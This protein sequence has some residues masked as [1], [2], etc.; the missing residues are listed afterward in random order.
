MEEPSAGA[1]VGLGDLDA[2][3]AEIEEAIDERA[4]NLGLFVHLADERLDLFLGKRADAVTKDDLVLG[5]DRQRLGMIDE[6]WTH[7]HGCYH[8][9]TGPR[10]TRTAR[11]TDIM[12]NTE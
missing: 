10:I 4:R 7:D 2:H 5:Q 12:D 6:L 9:H 3:D 11:A 1:A 8:R